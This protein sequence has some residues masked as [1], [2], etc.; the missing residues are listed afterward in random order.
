MTLSRRRTILSAILLA[1][2]PG[3]AAMAAG[4]SPLGVWIDHSG[5]GAVEITECGAKLCGRVVWLKKAENASTCNTQ[6]I[7]D[8]KAVSGGKW[9]N[10]WIYDPDTQNK[11]DVEITPMK[12]DRLKVY[13]YAGSKL[14]GETM[15]WT[16]A[17]ADLKRCD[18]VEEA[19]VTPPAAPVEPAREASP[20]GGVAEAVKPV[21]A[22]PA[23]VPAAPPAVA[24]ADVA[25]AET[26]AV[27]APAPAKEPPAV[28]P[29]KPAAVARKSGEEFEV[30]GV[31]VRL[32]KGKCGV[33]IKELGSFDFP[34][35]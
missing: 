16:R 22:L 21:D 24:P 34:C 14:F 17:P 26:A 11:Y 3:G 6:V 33:T 19:K 5:E 2:A 1:L 32:A 25:K 28:K 27:P 13:G 35:D 23:P 9:D 29:A 12:G 20:A 15:T 10:G 30:E 18:R 8:A 7:G 4:G 31:K